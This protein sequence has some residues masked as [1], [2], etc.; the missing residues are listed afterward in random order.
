MS[1]HS[2]ELK[3]TVF[4]HSIQSICYG[5]LISHLSQVSCPSFGGI[6]ERLLHCIWSHHSVVSIVFTFAYYATIIV[7]LFF[8]EKSISVYCCFVIL[9]SSLVSYKPIILEGWFEWYYVLKYMERIFR[10]YKIFASAY[11]WNDV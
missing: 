7:S 11:C 8:S 3:S 2:S 1:W 9:H 5:F 4:T 10:C 6:Q